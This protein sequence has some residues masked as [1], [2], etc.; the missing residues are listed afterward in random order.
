M[1]KATGWVLEPLPTQRNTEPALPGCPTSR[2]PPSCCHTPA[3]CLSTAG[4]V[5][6]CAQE[7]LVALAGV[8]FPFQ[9][10]R[11]LGPAP[12]PVLALWT[13]PFPQSPGVARRLGDRGGPWLT[14]PVFP[15]LQGTILQYV[16]TLME[17]MP[18]ICRLPRHEYGSPG[19]CG[20]PLKGARGGATPAHRPQRGES[21]A[22]SDQN[23]ICF[24]RVGAGAAQP[25]LAVSRR[26]KDV[27][28]R[29]V[30]GAV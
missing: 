19:E 10:W 27:C 4:C 13:D 24:F 25:E 5:S 2:A 3:T 20:R 16:K 28:L 21:W 23:P 15:Q 6:M 18:K 22:I 29:G 26:T 11:S 14:Q 12:S 9:A 7:C 17:V 1:H 8:G 30:G